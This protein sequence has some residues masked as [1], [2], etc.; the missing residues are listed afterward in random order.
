MRNVF[1]S[2]MTERPSGETYMLKRGFPIMGQ[3]YVANIGDTDAT[4][5]DSFC[6]VE[7][8]FGG[9]PMRRPYEGKKGNNPV[10][11]IIRPGD[12]KTVTFASGKVLDV[13]PDDILD[14]KGAGPLRRE[15]SLYV[16]GWIEYADEL[17]FV[18]HMAFCRW[19]SPVL[20]YFKPS[21]NPDYEHE[22]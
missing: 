1:L 5:K 9:L 21:D 15:L 22:E 17:G 18:R 2:E 19:F 8:R 16:M 12:P 6:M 3:F 7:W 20:N 4:I 13:D 10:S 11:G 14:P